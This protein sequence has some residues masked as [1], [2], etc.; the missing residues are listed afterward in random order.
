VGQEPRN[1]AA[2]LALAR[3]YARAGE[4]N[5]AFE[6]YVAVLKLEPGHASA[7]AEAARLRR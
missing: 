2:R 6:Q 3:A 7:V 4:P 1:V 5:A